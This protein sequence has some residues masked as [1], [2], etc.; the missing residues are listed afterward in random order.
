MY[1]EIVT[2]G[3]SVLKKDAPAN[4]RVTYKRTVGLRKPRRESGVCCVVQCQSRDCMGIVSSEKGNGELVSALLDSGAFP[5]V[6]DSQTV[7]WLALET[8]M[9]GISNK[10]FCLTREAI[11]EKKFYF[12]SETIKPCSS[13]L[14]N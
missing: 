10:L 6:M 7:R 2:R 5:S 9:R 4:R 12:I 14:K 8:H 13:F 3:G 11:N 1:A